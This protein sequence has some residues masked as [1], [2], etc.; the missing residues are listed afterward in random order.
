MTERSTTSAGI[1]LRKLFAKWTGISFIRRKYRSW[2]ASRRTA[3]E[4]AKLNKPRSGHELVLF[5]SFSSG[6]LDTLSEL[7][8]MNE[9]L[10]GLV[11]RTRSRLTDRQ[12]LQLVLSPDGSLYSKALLEDGG[13]R[14]IFQRLLGTGSFSKVKLA[15]DTKSGERVAIKMI[16]AAE[17]RATPRL[18][19][20]LLREVEIL[21]SLHHPN[22]VSYREVAVIGEAICLVMSYVPGVELFQWVA[23]NRRLGE[24]ETAV[25]LRQVLLALVYLH[26]RGIVH[27]DLKLENIL[28]ETSHAGGNSTY[29]RVTLVD[30]GLARML[31]SASGE[32]LMMCT[33][34]GS[35]EY[36]APEVIMGQPYDGRA[37]DAWSFGVVMFACLFGSLPFN[38]ETGRPRALAE[39]IVTASYRF[40]D[41]VHLTTSPMA[42]DLLKSLLV[43]DPAARPSVLDLL[44]HPWFNQV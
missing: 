29:P 15:I 3:A 7:T 32:Q 30:F 20:T 37:S 43:R 2:K 11:G 19:R 28:V 21:G 14:Y 44:D 1:S 24:R 4:V 34:C 41:D 22:I 8:L 17:V 35:E 36:A 9:S 16:S 39:K 23:E 31:R 42:V 40:P 18:Q 38:P 10:G 25:I 13:R 5:E 26:E 27:R 6:E 12:V 33:R